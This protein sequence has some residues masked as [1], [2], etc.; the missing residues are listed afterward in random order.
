M[1]VALLKADKKI[2]LEEIPFPE[3]SDNEVLVVE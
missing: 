3:I 1:K 2:V